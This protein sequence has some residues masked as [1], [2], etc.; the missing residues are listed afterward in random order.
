MSWNIK[1]IRLWIHWSSHWLSHESHRKIND[2]PWW[3]KYFSEST[4]TSIS[5]STLIWIKVCVWKQKRRAA[6]TWIWLV[7]LCCSVTV[8]LPSAFCHIN[9]K[10]RL[11]CK[12]N[13]MV[14]TRKVLKLLQSDQEREGDDRWIDQLFRELI[15]TEVCDQELMRYFTASHPNTKQTC[16]ISFS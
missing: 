8:L 4:N 15:H 11:Q 6:Q 3:K 10:E 14:R 1:L 7:L 12:D 13:L 2:S 16:S 9:N 5:W